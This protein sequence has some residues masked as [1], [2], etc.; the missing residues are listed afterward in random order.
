L[1]FDV[2]TFIMGESRVHKERHMT[3]PHPKQRPED[4]GHAYIEVDGEL[5]Y[6]WSEKDRREFD[7]MHRPVVDPDAEDA[8]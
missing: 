8:T 4:V 2:G 3:K 6:L 5:V 7:R 1:T